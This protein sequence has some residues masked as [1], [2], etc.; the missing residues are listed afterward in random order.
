MISIY[1]QNILVEDD[2]QFSK[3]P[4]DVIWLFIKFTYDVIFIDQRN[5]TDLAKWNRLMLSI[6][7]KFTMDSIL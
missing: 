1:S 4:S 7:G 6:G 3:L 5:G 2:E